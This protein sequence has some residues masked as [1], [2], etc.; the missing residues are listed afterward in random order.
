MGNFILSSDFNNQVYVDEFQ[1]LISNPITP[2]NSTLL[3]LPTYLTSKVLVAQLC[4]SLQLHG[5]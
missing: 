3:Y 5:L 4:D 2:L 1:A